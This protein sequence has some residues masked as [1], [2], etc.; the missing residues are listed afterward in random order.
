M[1]ATVRL[2]RQPHICDRSLLQERAPRWRHLPDDSEA[3]AGAH[4]LPMRCYQ[5]SNQAQRSAW[6]AGVFCCGPCRR[7]SLDWQRILARHH[8]T[9]M[10]HAQS[11]ALLTL[12]RRL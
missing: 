1:Q 2:D 5:R 4:I 11:K 12:L 6:Q 9:Q 7:G 3:P 10:Y 8:A